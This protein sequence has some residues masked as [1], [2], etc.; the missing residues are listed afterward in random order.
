MAHER[1]KGASRTLSAAAKIVKES[2]RKEAQE[3][4]E[5]VRLE[6]RRPTE[7]LHFKYLGV[8]QS[9]DADPMVPVNHRVTI[10]ALKTQSGY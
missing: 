4:L 7:G 1:A 6:R 9:G 5:K 2:K 3:K 8:M 10:S